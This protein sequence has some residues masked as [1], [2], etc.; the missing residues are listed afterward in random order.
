ML[1]ISYTNR[2]HTNR[3]LLIDNAVLSRHVSRRRR[4]S[5][6]TTTTLLACG[7]F[8]TLLNCKLGNGCQGLQCTGALH[9]HFSSTSML[10]E[11]E[12]IKLLTEG[13]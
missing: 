1:H 4:F 8:R 2:E 12:G 9:S 10:L 5:V 3:R 13:D 11:C 6:N 7:K